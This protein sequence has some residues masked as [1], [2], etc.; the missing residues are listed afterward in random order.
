MKN[1]ILI[2]IAVAF[3][4]CQRESPDFLGGSL[5]DQF[6][7]L[8]V[9]DSLKSNSSNFN[10]SVVS[11]RYFESQ[12]S[13]NLNWNL[14]VI[15]SQS[16]ATKTFTGFASK[17]DIDNSSWNGTANDFPS[18]LKETCTA[19]LTLADN[20]DTIVMSTTINISET[21]PLQDGLMVVADFEEGIPSNTI[22]IPQMGENMSFKIES[23][24]AANGLSY[25]A[26][27][28]IVNWDY[29]LGSIKIPVET[30]N[31]A[32]ISP[33]LLYF[34]MAITG[35]I[36][37]EVPANQFLKIY[38]READGERYSYEVNPVNWS[39]WQ[40][41]S[42]PYSDF[43]LDSEVVNNTKDPGTI[44][45]IEIMCLS[46]PSGPGA[47]AGGGAACPENMDLTVRTD[48]DFIAFSQNE[49]YKP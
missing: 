28:G 15:G 31:Y 29:Y 48:I 3:L 30:E 4:S 26:M 12:W 27:G 33:L 38:L 47:I 5:N 24:Q 1:I 11:P 36:I 22:V 2:L 49:S 45:Q 34:N 13:K 25:Y 10:F 21:K 39:N 16:G 35:G 8:L 43:I 18:F 46:C 14:S 19:T 7:D 9:L 6:G 32:N 40:L 41:L 23:G 17:I 42:V 44:N 20:V 37:G